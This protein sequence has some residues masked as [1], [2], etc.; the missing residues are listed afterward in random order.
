MGWILPL[1]S[2]VYD[3]HSSVS[4]YF[5]ASKSVRTGVVVVFVAVKQ[6]KE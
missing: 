5:K 4:L 6:K 2:L 3:L 1:C